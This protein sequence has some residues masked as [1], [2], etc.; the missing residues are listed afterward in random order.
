MT[1]AM[2]M[3]HYQFSNIHSVRFVFC[4][5][6]FGAVN[7]SV[8]SVEWRKKHWWI[9]IG[10]I[11]VKKKCW[12]SS[13][14]KI[15]CKAAIFKNILFVQQIL[16]S[17]WLEFCLIHGVPMIINIWICSTNPTRYRQIKLD[18]RNVYWVDLHI[19]F[20]HTPFRESVSLPFWVLLLLLLRKIHIYIYIDAWHF[21]NINLLNV[22][23][24]AFIHKLEH[25]FM[26]K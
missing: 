17:D 6:F 13:T 22:F 4:F 2:K 25:I 8:D 18:P 23:I 12:G 9:I 14:T 5:C 19:Y 26:F 24:I 3:T 16:R 7:A 15:K 1:L 21:Y 10:V 11:G 20:M